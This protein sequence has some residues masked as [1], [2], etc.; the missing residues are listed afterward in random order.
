MIQ[1]AMADF[2]STLNVMFGDRPEDVISGNLAGATT[3]LLSGEFNYL[4][5]QENCEPAFQ[6]KCWSDLLELPP[7]KE[8]WEA[9]EIL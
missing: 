8:V 3:V 2:P 5:E 4:L 1:Q 7:L 9:H 6:V